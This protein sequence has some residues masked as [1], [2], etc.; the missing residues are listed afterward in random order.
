LG[1]GWED[2]FKNML[3]KCLVGR[4]DDIITGIASPGQRRI[5]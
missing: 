1:I 2:E 3:I 5:F 4:K